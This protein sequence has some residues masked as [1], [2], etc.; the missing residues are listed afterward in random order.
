VSLRQ[1]KN[2]VTGKRGVVNSKLPE[3]V[4]PAEVFAELCDLLEDFSP[5]WY[6]EELHD[7]ALAA[8]R[9]LRGIFD[10]AWSN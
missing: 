10:Q 2:T 1:I 4:N 7:R 5:R 6:T 3:P 8:L 9:D